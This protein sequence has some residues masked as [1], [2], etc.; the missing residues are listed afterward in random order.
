V[1]GATTD[2]TGRGTLVAGSEDMA[3]VGAAEGSKDCAVQV[4]AAGGAAADG[5]AAAEGRTAAEGEA[6]EGEAA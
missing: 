1:A 5:G 4:R 3:K 6:A 2:A